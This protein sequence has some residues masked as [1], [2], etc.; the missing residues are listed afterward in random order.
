MAHMVKC[1]ICGEKFDRDKI[2]CVTYGTRRY[3]H[4]KCVEG[5]PAVA[6]KIK[7]VEELKD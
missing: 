2:E 7:E 3:A 4:L 5:E 1:A 6:A